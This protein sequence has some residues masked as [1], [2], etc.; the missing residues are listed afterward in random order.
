[1]YSGTL[2]RRTRQDSGWSGVTE[3]FAGLL[4]NYCKFAEICYSNASKFIQ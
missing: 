1:V 2:Y 3:L 4:D